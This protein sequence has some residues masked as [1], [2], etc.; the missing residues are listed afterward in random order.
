VP[1]APEPAPAESEGDIA[2]GGENVSPTPGNSVLDLLRGSGDVQ[3]PEHPEVLAP[4]APAEAPKP[5]VVLA[6]EAPAEAPKPEV[7]LAPEAP[8]E[9]PKPEVVLAPEVP[10]EAPKPEVVLAPEAPAETPKPEIVPA[11]EV[12]VETTEPQLPPAVEALAQK[13]GEKLSDSGTIGDNSVFSTE[14]GREFLVEPSG[15][16]YERSAAKLGGE[17]WKNVSDQTEIWTDARGKVWNYNAESNVAT[18]RDLPDGLTRQVLSFGDEGSDANRNPDSSHIAP[19]ENVLSS[20]RKDGSVEFAY[21]DGGKYIVGPKLW[22]GTDYKPAFED[23][24]YPVGDSGNGLNVRVNAN[25]AMTGN[26]PNGVTFSAKD[27]SGG[28]TLFDYPEGIAPFEAGATVNFSND[29]VTVIEPGGKQIV[30]HRDGSIEEH[31]SQADDHVHEEP[32]FSSEALDQLDQL[33]SDDKP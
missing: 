19:R 15:T 18:A 3:E 24:K 30:H 26:L 7:V 22:T 31:L 8:A 6:P 28:A 33:F 16:A 9:T 14:D 21:E 12:S 32:I 1:K 5:E 4:E 13:I 10:V 11:S 23:H 20:F 17:L 27:L 2:G 29:T 25:G